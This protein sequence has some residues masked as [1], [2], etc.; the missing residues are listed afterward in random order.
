M[1]VSRHLILEFCVSTY[2]FMVYC[3]L[4][5]SLY[6][7]SYLSRSFYFCLYWSSIFLRCCCVSWAP[8]LLR[9][10]DFAYSSEVISFVSST[11]FEWY[12]VFI[13][14]SKSVCIYC[15]LLLMAAKSVSFSLM[16]PSSW[17][18]TELC[19]SLLTS[20]SFYYRCPNISSSILSA[21]SPSLDA[22]SASPTIISSTSSSEHSWMATSSKSS[23]RTSTT[24]SA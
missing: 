2:F 6:P 11:I 9:F 13:I 8:F 22:W 17:R 7:H 20:W 12:W 10:S 4:F 16:E 24:G 1:S 23:S 3:S 15:W 21:P 18:M 19:C 5:F 14:S